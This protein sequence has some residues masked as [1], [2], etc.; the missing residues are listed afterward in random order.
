M[1]EKANGQPIHRLNDLREA[2][3]KP[4]NGFHIFEY[5]RGESLQRIVVSA[6]EGEHQATQR[7]LKRY[8]ITEDSHFA[9]R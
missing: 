1:I 7:V 9:S 3:K 6:G 5:T 8:G 4:V 2:L